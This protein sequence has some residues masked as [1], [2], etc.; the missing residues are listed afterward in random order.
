M[1][2][3]HPPRPAS[4]T[5]PRPAGRDLRETL[6]LRVDVVYGKGVDALDTD[7]RERLNALRWLY[8]A[9]HNGYVALEALALC[10][11]VNPPAWVLAAL[12]DAAEAL[13]ECESKG[14]RDA[15]LD[16]ALRLSRNDRD[17]LRQVHKEWP[18]MARMNTLI[19]GGSTV[20]AA[21][22]KVQTEA[23]ERRIG[24]P[25]TDALQKHWHGF[26]KAFF[27]WRRGEAP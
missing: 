3:D 13:L 15:A 27:A 4:R 11:G 17:E 25:S 8:G 18:H 6:A 9:T 2:G 21:A 1:R 7:T 16:G 14:E 19:R 23:E 24:S 22:G 20:E 5:G 10:R 12:T 26:W